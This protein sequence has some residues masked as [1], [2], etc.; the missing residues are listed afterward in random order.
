MTERKAYI[1]YIRALACIGIVFLHTFT[2]C[3]MAYPDQMNGVYKEV[4]YL[5]P[6][7]MMWAVPC[8]VMVTGTLLLDNAK[9]ITYGKV[10]KKYI[11]RV[12]KALIIC[13]I[14]FRFLDVWMNKEK[15]SAAVFKD[16]LYK[17]YTATSWAHLWYLYLIIGLYLLMPVFKK[18]TENFETKDLLI[19][20]TIY[21]VFVSVVP[22]LNDM[23]G[24]TT[25]FYI[26]TNSI[27]P[28]Y[29]IM[30][31]MIDSDKFRI[32]KSVAC[33][34][35]ILGAVSIVV[36]NHIGINT[37]DEKVSSLISKNLGSYAFIPVLI[38]SVGAFSLLGQIG[39]NKKD[40][41][42]RSFFGKWLLSV[43][44][45]SFGIYL[46]HL[47]FLRYVFKC[48]DFNPFDHSAVPAACIFATAV[49][50]LSYGS[51]WI[52]NLIVNKIVGD[53]KKNETKE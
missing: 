24:I 10:F 13:V 25:G 14:V 46:I 39:K 6:Y 52:Y 12:L 31:H 32:R 33:I 18:I 20:C 28:A 2:M 30:G 4:F 37:G 7:L 45:C 16:M 34:C 47:V 40:E 48:T 27:F 42:T 9:N 19:L 38:M 8:F 44:K 3:T 50:I 1:S 26:T 35:L 17:F 36:I 21:V 22:L 41:T 11:P 49:F 5:I 23:T 15:F 51:V 53:K 29:L 43:D